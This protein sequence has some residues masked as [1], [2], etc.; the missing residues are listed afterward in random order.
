MKYSGA[1]A[2]ISLD[3]DNN[4]CKSRIQ[5]SYRITQI[6]ARLRESRTRRESRMLQK[7]HN[8]LPV[9]SLIEI[10]DYDIVM[11]NIEGLQAKKILDKS[12]EI[13]GLIGKNLSLMHDSNII[14]GDL[15]T[16]NMILKGDVLYFIDFGLSF[17][18]AKIEDKA[19]DIHLFRQA[20]LSRHFLVAEQAYQEFLKGYQPKDRK[21]ILDRLRVVEERG[22]YKEKT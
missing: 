12:P 22:R 11:E 1:E 2:I 15:T 16:S 8:I 5:K 3:K 20:L 17:T 9:P 19:V 6:D 18:S 14:H 7:L 10:K 21:E 13:A 4:I